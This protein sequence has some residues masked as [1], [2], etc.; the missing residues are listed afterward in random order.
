MK[1]TIEDN[2]KDWKTG[3]ENRRRKKSRD[4][5]TIGYSQQRS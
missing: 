5:N 2:G 4:E 1:E 3:D